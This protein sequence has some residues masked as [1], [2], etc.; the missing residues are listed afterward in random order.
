MGRSPIEDEVI[1]GYHIPA[2]SLIFASPW[3]T[4]RHPEIWEDPEGFDP[5]RFLPERAAKLPRFAYFP[6]GGGPRQCIGNGFAMM[7]AALVLATILRRVRL[8]LV[9]GQRVRPEPMITLRP[10]DGLFMT[11]R[12]ISP[13]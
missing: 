9:P 7:E 4:H 2:R 13:S 6:F 5:D 11:A 3:A 8:E 1:G 12:R 10:K